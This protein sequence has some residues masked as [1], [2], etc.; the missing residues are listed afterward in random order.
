VPTLYKSVCL[1]C[2][3]EFKHQRRAAKYCSKRCHYQARTRKREKRED[4]IQLSNGQWARVSSDDLEYLRQYGWVLGTTGYARYGGP[5]QQRMHR[6]VMARAIGRE[7]QPSETLDHINGDK[8]D[9]RRSNLRL[10]THAENLRNQRKRP[11]GLSGYVGVSRTR[12][13]SWRAFLVL[14]AKQHS[15]GCFYDP[16]EAAWMRDQWALELHGEF[17]RLNFEYV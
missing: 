4:A 1:C 6:I 17:A 16:Q 14:D 8:L 15:V 10:C 13:G 2:Q 11:V 3:L 12:H 5:G 9:N 7:L